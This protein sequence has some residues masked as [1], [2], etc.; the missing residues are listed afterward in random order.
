MYFCKH[1]EKQ[2]LMKTIQR[3]ILVYFAC[4]SSLVM[5]QSQKELGQLMRDRGEYYFTLTVD[6]PSE[7]QDI[8]M[9]CSV[10]GTDGR[11]VVCYANQQQYDKLLQVGYEPNLQ[12]P[13]SLREEARMWE[14]GD[15]ATY[16]WDS[17]PTYSQ[18]ASMMQ[19]FPASAVS[20]RTCTYMELG[21]LNSG[22][23]IMGV[24]INNGSPE[25]KPKFLYSSTIHGD[26]T[27]G[28]ILMLRLIDELCTS[29][30]SRIVNLVD[31]LDIFIFPN[32]NPDGT[33]YGGNNTVTGARRA[34]ANG[35]DM[36]RN[37]PDP[38]SSAHPDGNAYQTETQWF[39]Q[40]AED[41]A[42]TMA[43]NYHGGAEVVNYPWDN[44]STR[45]ADDAWWQYVSREYANLCHAVSSSYMTDQSNGITN[46]ADWYMIGGGRQDY[47]NG[48]RQCREVT[49]ECST[50]KNPSGSQ[51]PTFWNYNHNSMLAYME[52]CLNGVH[53][54]V[55]DAMTDEPLDGVTV[56]VL[57]HDDQY[58]VVSTHEDGD[59]HRPIKGGTWD[60][61]FSKSGYC[62][63]TVSVTVADDQRE[64]IVVY[65]YPEGSCPIA[66]DCYE[67]TMPTAAG[68]YVMGYLDGTTLRMPTHNGSSTITV[69]SSNVTTSTNGFIV[70]SDIPQVIL[71]A[72]GNNGQY[73]IKYNNRYLTRSTSSGNLSWETSSYSSGSRWYINNNGIYV[74]R[75]NSNYYLYYSDGF[76][77][78][79]TQQNNINFYVEG[80][81][82]FTKDIVGYDGTR[83]RYYLIAS[84]IGTINTEDVDNLLSNQYDLYCFDQ[85]QDLEWINYEQTNGLHPFTNL[86]AGT[87]YL[88]ANNGDVT[89]AFTGYPYRGSAMFTLTK[90]DDV[91]FSGWNLVGN[92]FSWTTYINRPFYR[93]NEYGSE[94]IVSSG[95]ID[96]MEGVFVVATEDD[97]T[98]VFSPVESNSKGAALEMEI[99]Q[100]HGFAI[101]RAIIRFGEATTM[102]K[103][104]LNRNNTL[105]YLPQDDMDYAMISAN[106]GMGEIPV[107]FKAAENGI[108]TLSFVSKEVSFSYLHLIDNKTGTEVD[109]LANASYTFEAQASDYA[110][111]FKLVFTSV[112]GDANGDNETFAFNSN[113]TWFIANEGEATVQV[114]DVMG[115]ILKSE[116]ID[117]CHSLNFKAAPGVYLIRLV[118]GDVVKVQKIVIE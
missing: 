104:M 64:D 97:E 79:T 51:L 36:N 47:M 60:F 30:D 1:Y 108:Y 93:L 94:L 82:V 83:D 109:L 13:P 90:V 70:E 110:N 103:I 17:Y 62:D 75:N 96:A 117:G 5:A 29:T 49:V 52:Q 80:D 26:E 41:Y 16:E 40:L 59:F 25:G 74:T 100:N 101:D 7:I 23:K 67:Q 28:W 10:D 19:A 72:Y 8:N 37:Y 99:S 95:A 12:T 44:T 39:M 115:R 46:G 91:A 111:R 32:T 61:T 4:V 63:E 18:Y 102:P 76:K 105:V 57:N 15:R 118:K 77:L 56:T 65:L 43:A 22:R 78:S 27:T 50:T 85:S 73:Y 53:G 81:C 66:I 42:F 84:P 14:G 54:M 6:D 2:L 21:T 68:N 38:H 69:T 55:Y 11:T 106:D 112:C 34:N 107:C 35:I 98:I 24:R 71:T 114:I 87:G 48:Y 92:P 113:G 45:H 3:L 116:Q 31:N 88:Y 20:G 58:S 89:L 86:E 33:Y 9:L